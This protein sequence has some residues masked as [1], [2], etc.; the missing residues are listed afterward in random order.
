M[1]DNTCMSALRAVFSISV[2]QVRK[3]G[4]HQVRVTVTAGQLG[5]GLSLA[6]EGSR[7]VVKGFR[8][9]S[10]GQANP[11]QASYFFALYLEYIN[12]RNE[13]NIRQ[14]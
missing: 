6:D 1:R 5:L 3:P 8:P 7:C 10:D 2:V 13:K 9:M 11:G 4:T 12:N 14:P